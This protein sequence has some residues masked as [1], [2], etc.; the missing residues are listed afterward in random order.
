VPSNDGNPNDD[1][2]DSSIALV[3][4]GVVMR[5]TAMSEVAVLT[6]KSIGLRIVDPC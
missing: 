4:D 6:Y 2:D 5:A 3:G 1:D